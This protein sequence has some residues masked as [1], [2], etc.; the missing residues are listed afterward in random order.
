MR[1]SNHPSIYLHMYMLMFSSKS[2]TSFVL[3][4]FPALI[5]RDVLG[6]RGLH[7]L[8]SLAP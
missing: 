7:L 5:A 2:A 4:L 6:R 3:N 8:L 1:S